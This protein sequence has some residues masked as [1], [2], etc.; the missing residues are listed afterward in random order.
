VYSGNGIEVSQLASDVGLGWS[1][2][3][4]GQIIRSVRDV[5]DDNFGIFND[6]HGWTYNTIFNHNVDCFNSNDTS[7]D[8]R[9]Y[10][11]VLMETTDLEPDCFSYNC[12]S[13]SGS[14]I[15]NED[16]V[17]DYSFLQ[18]PQTN[19]KILFEL[20][21]QDE[22]TFKIIDDLGTYYQFDIPDS[23]QILGRSINIPNSNFTNG[24]INF[25]GLLA[26]VSNQ[27]I[28]N[29]WSFFSKFLTYTYNYSLFPSSFVTGWN[30]SKIITNTKSEINFTYENELIQ[31]DV[32]YTLQYQGFLP[33][34]EPKKTAHQAYNTIDDD[35]FYESKINRI[36]E[37]DSDK[38]K[39]VFN[40][41][42]AREDVG[43]HISDLDKISRSLSSIEIFSKCS[44]SDV[45]IKKVEFVYSYFI[46]PSQVSDDP[47]LI[48]YDVSSFKRLKLDQVK[49]TDNT[50][51][52]S[53]YSFDYDYDQ[54]RTLPSRY[55]K[56]QDFWGYYDGQLSDTTLIPTTFIYNNLSG[57][58]RFTVFENPNAKT[59]P[60]YTL[61]WADRRPR[62]QFT[63]I[64]ILKKIQYPTGGFSLI[65]YESNT[66][67]YYELIK[68]GPGVRVS[69]IQTFSSLDD[70]HPIV[71]KYE[72]G[73]KDEFGLYIKSY[74]KLNQLPHFGYFD[75]IFDDGDPFTQG[76]RIMNSDLSDYSDGLFGY[77]KVRISYGENK[78]A[79]YSEFD[80]ENSAMQG[81][82]D[83]YLNFQPNI[84]TIFKHYYDY[85]PSEHHFCSTY[86]DRQYPMYPFTIQ[87][88]YDWIRGNL[89]DKIDYNSSGEI[90]ASKHI[91]YQLYYHDG[92]GAKITQPLK[93]AGYANNNQSTQ[94]GNCG[95]TKIS[96]NLIVC[97][98]YRILSGVAYM[99]LF[100]QENYYDNSKGLT[101][102]IQTGFDLN[103]KGQIF[104]EVITHP[105]NYQTV[106]TT[107]Y[108]SDYDCQGATGPV[109]EAI[110]RMQTD[111]NMI[112]C[113]VETTKSVIHEGVEQVTSGLINLYNLKTL[114]SQNNP[115][116]VVSAQKYL[117]T[118]KPLISFEY[119]TL[120]ND[121]VTDS[122]YPAI[123]QTSLTYHQK[124]GE[125]VEHLGSD[126]K[127]STIIH[128]DIGN[129]TLA[130]VDGAT[131]NECSYTGFE[132]FE[133][134]GWEYCPI[135][136]SQINPSWVFTGDYATH[137]SG[138]SYMRRTVN[139]GVKAREHKGYTVS[140]WVKGDDHSAYMSIGRHG[141]SQASFFKT[142]NS[143][144]V[145]QWNYL[146][147]EI[148]YEFLE[149]YIIDGLQLEVNVGTDGGAA[150]FDEIRI[151]PSDAMMTSKVYNSSLQ[152][153][154]ESDVRGIPMIYFYDSFGRIIL[155][156][157]HLGNILKK[158][159]YTVAQ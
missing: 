136:T 103:N 63:S 72:Y 23:Y 27:M 82:V 67:E 145:G 28:K 70:I 42:T 84:S 113:P 26:R 13:L 141:Q 147:V 69:K 149:P 93:I 109:A 90:V 68:P 44:G 47:N 86:L 116:V 130:T 138:P 107:K 100:V 115:I 25:G 108:I 137:F 139:V 150:S 1:L 32:G 148:P 57:S 66:F 76:F 85:P 75:P 45:L 7:Y 157:D 92:N 48:F 16:D 128:N 125:M 83:P 121:L 155:V 94:T 51:T 105:D 35:Y 134:D 95:P 33:N 131:R 80:F 118:D 15:F 24:M 120:L 124:S 78:E 123:P 153:S 159:E 129:L 98:R 54:Q 77:S 36:K 53:K 110:E 37:I 55:S 6:K 52:L 89:T 56:S 71:N 20:N 65:D 96:N 91:N 18:I 152:V 111:L 41:L 62:E 50:N 22:E 119:S 102:G 104:R 19:N 11:N 99:P 106:N 126:G 3:A 9:L 112:A 151:R 140:A 101:S 58:E 59:Q 14:F 127:N 43:Q 73:E 61:S 142:L 5:P 88:N 64:G 146:E 132:F 114:E 2:E 87:T 12:N 135:I 81:E 46:S 30:V 29:N 38:Y 21:S 17:I 40:Y 158:Y 133:K 34:Q 154:S 31:N 122:H 49:I 74:G 39:V 8:N 143:G 4:G 117:E 79:G 97:S 156:K 10:L 60:D 144:T